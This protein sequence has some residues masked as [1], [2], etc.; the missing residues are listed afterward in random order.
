MAPPSSDPVERGWQLLESGDFEGAEETLGKARRDDPDDPEVL[1]LAGAIAAARGEVDD[2]LEILARA[3]A[4][5][6][7]Y[8]H[9]LLQAGELEL[10]SRGDAAAA[11]RLAERALAVAQGDE[12]IADALLL[13]AEAE[14]EDEDDGERL[15]RATMHAVDRL[16]L[17]DPVLLTRA[18][19]MYLA[20]EDM[21]RAERAFLAAI[22]LDG[23]QADAHHGL[24][25]VFEERGDHEAMVKAWLDTRRLDQAAPE[26]PWHLDPREFE[27]I[28]EAA[29]EELPD[30]VISRLEN[31]PVLIE[32]LP[33]EDLVAEGYDPRLL[34]L[35]S[36]VPL[37]DKSHVA[38]ASPVI[39][40]VHLYQRNI[41]RHSAD[42]DELAEEIRIT[43]IHE[44]A[45]FFGL[46]DD[47]LEDL[48]LG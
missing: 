6:P 47:D 39:D 32:D 20:L 9:P 40:S 34:G 3:A 22:D 17:G 43:V 41:E 23:S 26:P 10:Y 11:C 38:G 1:C 16:D 4:A 31:V 13:R 30:E 33:G 18:G 29:M 24:G 35:F 48:G 25:L 8:A 2:A 5:D 42:K 15:A 14:L 19:Q 12:E 36:G 27:R 7:E 28:A 37:P 44:T 45:H 21:R 46:D